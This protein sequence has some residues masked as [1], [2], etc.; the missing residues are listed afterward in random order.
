VRA[1]SGAPA[2]HAFG[3][4][5]TAK[6]VH[7]AGV[8]VA[9]APYAWIAV[10]PSPDPA[11]AIT[12][13]QLRGDETAPRPE[14]S[15]AHVSLGGARVPPAPLANSS[16]AYGENAVSVALQSGDCERHR[17]RP[18]RSERLRLAGRRARGAVGS[19]R[20]HA[21]REHQSAWCKLTNSGDAVFRV[22]DRFG[23]GDDLHG[24]TG[25]PAPLSG[26]HGTAARVVAFP[27]R[28]HLPARG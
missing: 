19:C 23:K 5:A 12:R 1:A 4:W 2:P 10:A 22:G 7:A 6:A 18:A 14:P 28:Y 17:R 26:D 15:R 27:N 9:V 24:D 8:R 3:V 11:R 20:V 25:G 21:H 13:R 16:A